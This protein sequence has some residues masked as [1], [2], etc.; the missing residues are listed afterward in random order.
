MLAKRVDQLDHSLEDALLRIRGLEKQLKRILESQKQDNHT[1]GGTREKKD[2]RKRKS[3]ELQQEE[4]PEGKTDPVVSSK[5]SRQKKEVPPTTSEI[6]PTPKHKGRANPASN[7]SVGSTEKPQQATQLVTP[8]LAA[9]TDL[10]APR[11]DYKQIVMKDPIAE[12]RCYDVLGLSPSSSIEVIKRAFK[13][14]ALKA[15]PDKPGGSQAA[16]LCLNLAFELLS[17]VSR[18]AVYDFELKQIHSKDGEAYQ[19]SGAAEDNAIISAEESSANP[20]MMAETFLYSPQSAWAALIAMLTDRNLFVLVR[21][22]QDAK[23]GAKQRGGGGDESQGE[24]RGSQKSVPGLKRSGASK[25]GGKIAVNNWLIHGFSTQLEDALEARMAIGSLRQNLLKLVEGGA[26]IHDALRAEVPKL[27]EKDQNSCFFLDFSFEYT[28]PKQKIRLTTP[29]NV[30]LDQALE[31]AQTLLTLEENKAP[32]SEFKKKHGN[33]LLQMKQQRTR[34]LADRVNVMAR[35]LKAT[36]A[37]LTKRGLDLPGEGAASSSNDAPAPP[38]MQIKKFKVTSSN[39]VGILPRP[40]PNC[41]A[42]S[43]M[44]PGAMFDVSIVHISG[45]QK[46]FSL[47]DGSGWLPQCSRKD[48]SRIVVEQIDSVFDRAAILDDTAYGM[49]SDDGKSSSSSSSSSSS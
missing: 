42:T 43:Y 9:Q 29:K 8:S 14:R 12:H 11:P 44:K 18:R 19:S 21:H 32:E 26:S 4:P 41:T 45:G 10:S 1:T 27:R 28:R 15:H 34:T 16:F 22:L 7:N 37:E 47:S 6:I 40:D 48:A 35:L 5:K 25:F 2:K 31:H 17:D 36:S 39:K 33:M 24:P 30:D 3:G 23:K 20:E 13:R 38:P 46:F 49:D